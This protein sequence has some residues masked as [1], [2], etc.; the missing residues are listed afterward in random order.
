MC[1]KTVLAYFEAFAQEND[2]RKNT[3]NSFSQGGDSKLGPP[4]YEKKNIHNTERLT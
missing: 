2:E 4:K 1:I 3:Q